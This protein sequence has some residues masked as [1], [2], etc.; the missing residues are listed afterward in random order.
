VKIGEVA[1]GAYHSLSTLLKVLIP[2][3]KA[4]RNSI[5]VPGDTLRIKL[6]GDG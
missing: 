2:V 5:I 3:W 4:G 6:G 1:N